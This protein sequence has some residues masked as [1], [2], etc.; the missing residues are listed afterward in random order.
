M[1]SP[2]HGHSTGVSV[3]TSETKEQ[4]ARKS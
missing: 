4:N 2:F 3:K 1:L